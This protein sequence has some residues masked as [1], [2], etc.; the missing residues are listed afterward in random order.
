MKT[1]DF[2]HLHLQSGQRVL[3]L[4]CGEGRHAIS[5]WLESPVDV[6]G[7]DLSPADLRTAA[8]RA[9]EFQPPAEASRGSLGWVQGSGLTLPFADASFDRVICAEVL[10]HVPDFHSVLG[11]IRRVLKPG[12]VLAVSV[13]RFVP[14]WLCWQLSD[15]YHEVP[16]GHIRIFRTAL[17][18]RAVE[19]QGL[20]RYHRHWA[21]SLHVPYW[22]LRC[23]FWDR[24]ESAW[25]VRAYHRL[26]VW[27]L[28]RRPWLTRLLDRLLNPVMGKSVVLY[29]TRNPVRPEA[30]GT[31][32]P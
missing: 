17:L 8:G 16:G 7:L 5:A 26:L 11:E 3:D 2:R 6:V 29:F 18:T 15:A 10:E 25:P 4:G 12:G 32:V 20:R 24:G 30:G 13:P 21:H 9:A 1:I 31:A 27:D 14:E 23:L 28:M 19:G 22:W